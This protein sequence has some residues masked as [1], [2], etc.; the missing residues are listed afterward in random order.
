MDDRWT[1]HT[2][3]KLC[4]SETSE[5]VCGGCADDRRHTRVGYPALTW[6]K[7]PTMPALPGVISTVMSSFV[8]C[9]Y[10]C[11]HAH[12]RNEFRGR[13]VVRL[14]CRPSCLEISVRNPIAAT[15]HAGLT[16]AKFNLSDA[17]R[18]IK[19]QGNVGNVSLC[20]MKSEDCFVCELQTQV[21]RNRSV[22]TLPTD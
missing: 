16:C 11:T 3:E 20:A 2:A 12:P 15:L 18:R 6:H 22:I 8:V 4:T 10:V 9:A 5:I 17:L 1:C 21:A 19:I 7:I 13:A 14:L